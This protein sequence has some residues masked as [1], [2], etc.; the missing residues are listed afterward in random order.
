MKL[1]I[2]RASKR[3]CS[4]EQVEMAPGAFKEGKNWFIEIKTLEDLMALSDKTES[5]IVLQ[6]RWLCKDEETRFYLTVYDDYL[7]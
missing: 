2:E 7:E 5:C 6:R 4:N 1:E 3:Y